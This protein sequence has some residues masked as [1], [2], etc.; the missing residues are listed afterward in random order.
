MGILWFRE[1]TGLRV[2]CNTTGRWFP[3]RTGERQRQVLGPSICVGG[4]LPNKMKG[5]G[6]KAL[7][8][9][10]ALLTPGVL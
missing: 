7:V 10:P 4:A 8:D 6:E 2:L 5:A 9:T 3:R 1:G